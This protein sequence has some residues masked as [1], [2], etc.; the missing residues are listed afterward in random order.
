VCPELA[1]NTGL[2]DSHGELK[3]YVTTRADAAVLRLDS[4]TGKIQRVVAICE[5]KWGM[6]YQDIAESLHN[7]AQFLNREP[8]LG[9][10]HFLLRLV[11]DPSAG[12]IPNNL[13]TNFTILPVSGDDISPQFWMRPGIVEIGNHTVEQLKLETIIDSVEKKSATVLEDIAILQLLYEKMDQEMRELPRVAGGDL[14]GRL[15]H[16]LRVY[17]DMK[18]Y[19]FQVLEE[20]N[21]FLCDVAIPA[22]ERPLRKKEFIELQLER[23]K[24]LIHH[25]DTSR[26]E[27]E[28]RTCRPDINPD[29]LLHFI[30]GDAVYRSKLRFEGGSKKGVSG[31][32]VV[33]QSVPPDE[34][35]KR[36]RRVS[37]EVIPGIVDVN[38]SMAALL[39]TTV[40]NE[41]KVMSLAMLAEVNGPQ[42]LA[43]L[44]R[45]LESYTSI[46]NPYKVKEM[47]HF[48]ERFGIVSIQNGE[49]R[50]TE[51]GTVLAAS[52][53][54]ILEL[55]A[56]PE[57]SHPLVSVFGY[58]NT[59]GVN[60]EH[61]G[62]YNVRPVRTFH[63]LSL[64]RDFQDKNSGRSFPRSTLNSLL[65][66]FYPRV[67]I[68]HII[69]YLLD[70]GVI[71]APNSREL[72]IPSTQVELLTLELEMANAVCGFSH[73]DEI[74]LEAGR[75]K[76]KMTL[77]NT[78]RMN[79]LLSRAYRASPYTKSEKKD[80]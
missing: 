66:F 31:Q 48:M 14:E 41:A 75:K 46:N 73:V 30:I 74:Y 19:F 28:L 76:A 9:C 12:D 37:I 63:V 20:A 38:P 22:S 3:A 51:K 32:E 2:D 15:K 45:R 44:Q 79:I 24:G 71:A 1:L 13:Q 60:P 11:G 59:S 39:I 16:R 77:G 35:K 43:F 17:K 68:D 5:D 36:E 4:A 64:L 40:N 42:H 33:L 70:A 61:G 10:R 69:Q 8:F 78:D 67:E 65:E 55:V 26:L 62:K 52:A 47:Y 18:L 54:H 72:R 57:F 50:L 7:E 6:A 25:K 34:Q 49:V 53:G 56:S 27:E 29:T 23:L 80:A 21:A 58:V